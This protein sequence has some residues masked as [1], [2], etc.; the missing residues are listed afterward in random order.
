MLKNTLF[1]T[2]CSNFAAWII[3]KHDF[4]NV[5]FFKCV[6]LE[7]VDFFWSGKEKETKTEYSL[8]V[9]NNLAIFQG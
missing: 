9:K 8:S 7:N 1:C 2:L 3:F 5:T 6:K 4:F